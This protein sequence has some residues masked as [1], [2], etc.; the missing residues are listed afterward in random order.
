MKYPA[1]VQQEVNKW[2]RENLDPMFRP[3]WGAIKVS[4][5]NTYEHN[6][7]VCKVA[8]ALL[9]EGI[10][11]CTEARLKCGTRPDIIAPTHIRQ[12]IEVLWSET[13]EDFYAK[14]AH[15]MPE[16]LLRGVLFVDAAKDFEPKM[17]W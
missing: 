15:K 16:E 2:A 12:Y 11:F 13:P 5:A 4:K 17:L 14:K 3:H 9:D 6:L 10:P 7:M 1:K 8:L